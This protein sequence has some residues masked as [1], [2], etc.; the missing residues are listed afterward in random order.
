MAL[1]VSRRC[2]S[3]RG[4]SGD[5]WAIRNPCGARSELQ[6]WTRAWVLGV[7]T[8][9]RCSG[10]DGL[11]RSTDPAMRRRRSGGPPHLECSLEPIV[12]TK[13]RSSGVG[14]R[15]FQIPENRQPRPWVTPRNRYVQVRLSASSVISS[16]NAAESLCTGPSERIIRI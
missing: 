2:A 11:L 8:S 13:T 9:W 14:A 12:D 4:E 3:A 6:R 1:H 7:R 5:Q 10:T 15:A 16:R